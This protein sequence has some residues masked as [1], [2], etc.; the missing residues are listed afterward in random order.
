MKK[1]LCLLILS[2]SILLLMPTAG[3]KIGGSPQGAE[4]MERT[5]GRNVT[6]YQEFNSSWCAVKFAP[7]EEIHIHEMWINTSSV[8][9]VRNDF[10][11]FV[12]FNEN[13]AVFDTGGIGMKIENYSDFF[14]HVN[15]LS[16]NFTVEDLVQAG[17]SGG[18]KYPRYDF[19]LPRG[20]YYLVAFHPGGAYTNFTIWMNAAPRTFRKYQP[21]Q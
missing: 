17:M 5:S 18:G 7:S 10:W 13:K 19:T 1:N 8:K 20:C 11:E 21:R 14:L 4:T 15:F 3:T 9:N 16:L 2:L 12:L 6:F